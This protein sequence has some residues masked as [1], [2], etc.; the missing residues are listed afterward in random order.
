[1]FHILNMCNFFGDKRALYLSVARDM[2]SIKRQ[3]A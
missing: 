2:Y 3:A 1:M